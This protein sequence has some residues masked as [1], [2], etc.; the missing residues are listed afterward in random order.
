MKRFEHQVALV[1]GASAGIG[2]AIARRLQQEGATVFAAQRRPVEGL[3]FIEADL[4]DENCPGLIA[5]TIEQEAGRLDILVNNAG[6]MRESTVAK[7]S[8]EDWSQTLAVNLT[9]PFLL[10]QATLPLLKRNRGRIINIGSIEGLAAN[11]LHS[12]YC[13]SKAGL[14]G[15]TRAFAVDLGE[16][17]I[18]C[19][20]VAPGWINTDLNE[21]F[22]N[23][24]QDP[25]AFRRGIG[26]IH[27]IGRTGTP[28]E[29]ASLVAFLA[30]EDS[31][32]ITGQVFTADGGRT[33]Q[34][35]LP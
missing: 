30:S 13:A 21:E 35:S 15:L 9:A 32:F 6:I 4:L 23:N 24:Q 11:P 16:D 14:H 20:A 34:L 22:I 12:A 1:T 31:E 8:L 17:G 19:N 33:S 26:G 27:P 7:Q 3:Q 2:L 5:E 18:R 25:E 29:V 28:E 10:V